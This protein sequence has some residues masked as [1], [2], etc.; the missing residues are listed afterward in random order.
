[1]ASLIARREAVFHRQGIY[2]WLDGRTYLTTT[3]VGH[4]VLEVVIV[5]TTYV[6]LNIA[7]N[8]VHRHES[9][10]QKVLVIAERIHRSHDGITFA[11]V[12]KYGHFLLGIERLDDFLFRATV[13]LHLAVTV[14]E[15][16]G[17][18][19]DGI[20]LFYSQ[21]I[22]KR[23]CLLLGL[24]LEETWLKIL[25]NVFIYRFFGISLHT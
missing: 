16:H 20:Y 25:G 15:T 3:Y 8:R 13:A 6:S 12:G 2:I 5:C 24:R 4:I 9:G 22:S 18:I 1:M 17:L 7:G 11:L 10:T 23:S 21:L 14:G 19:H